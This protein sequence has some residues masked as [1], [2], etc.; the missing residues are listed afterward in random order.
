VV[1]TAGIVVDGVAVDGIAVDGIAVD[2]I[3]DGIAVDGIV[4]GTA[5]DLHPW[6]L[7][8]FLGPTLGCLNYYYIGADG[9]QFNSS[10]GDNSSEQISPT[11]TIAAWGTFLGYTI[12]NINKRLPPMRYPLRLPDPS[13]TPQYQLV[14]RPPASCAFSP[15]WK[16]S[17]LFINNHVTV[18]NDNGTCVSEYLCYSPRHFFS[19]N[20]TSVF[21]VEEM[22]LW[23]EHLDDTERTSGLPKRMERGHWDRRAIVQTP[24]QRDGVSY[25]EW[26][27][28]A[29]EYDSATNEWSSLC[30]EVKA[31]Y[32]RKGP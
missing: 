21:D 5:D 16:L 19:G 26:H 29:Y 15:V 25:I 13:T 1:S 24:V 10:G 17:C 8:Q 22:R 18:A 4:D 9:S 32:V 7:R 28:L 11:L 23:I 31:Y 30:T 2:G 14:V 12:E 20:V 3:A 6:F 27:I